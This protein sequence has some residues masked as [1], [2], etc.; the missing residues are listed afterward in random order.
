MKK[1]VVFVLFVVVMGGAAAIALYERVR[2]PYKGYEGAEQFVE[3]PPGMKTGAIAGALASTGFVRDEPTFRLALWM[4]GKGRHLQAG[5]Y[6]FDR[7]MTPIEVVDKIARGDV[8][9]IPITFPE[10]LTLAEMA[11][12]F[13]SNGFGPAESFVE[14]ASDASLV[15]A[16][17]PGAKDLEGYLFPDTYALPRKTDGPRLVRRMVTA[18]EHALTP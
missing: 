3:V 5:E 10:G 6:R 1:L 11:K 15:R 2:Q 18:F 9:T 16:F 7:P 14:A 13:E 12:I 4:S 8:F 17:D